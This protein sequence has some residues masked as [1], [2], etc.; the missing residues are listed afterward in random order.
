MVIDDYKTPWRM[1]VNHVYEYNII[2]HDF[3]N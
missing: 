1:L 2:S 3:N